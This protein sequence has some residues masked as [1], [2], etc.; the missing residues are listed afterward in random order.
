MKT[1]KFTI[2]GNDYEVEIKSVDENKALVGVNGTAFEV[3]MHKPVKTTKTPTLVRQPAKPPVGP[4]VKVSSGN[5]EVRSPLPGNVLHLHKK[6][7][8]TVTRGELVLTYEAMKMENKILAEK[9]G[10]VRNLK[11]QVGDTFLQN[12]VLFEIE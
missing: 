1:F 6:N 10:V 7:G 2:Q 8:D 9:D 5:V 11:L 3:I 12:D 4:S